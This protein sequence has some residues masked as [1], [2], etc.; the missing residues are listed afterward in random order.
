[1]YNRVAG[2]ELLSTQPCVQSTSSS[3]AR[4]YIGIY[5]CAHG[6]CPIRKRNS[7]AFSG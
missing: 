5:L 3:S 2:L 6:G 7:W 1:M 4:W